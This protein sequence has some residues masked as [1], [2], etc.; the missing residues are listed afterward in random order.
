MRNLK[1]KIFS[2]IF[3]LF[4]VT[5]GFSARL[6]DI[7]DIEGVRGNYLIGY[8]LV[9][10]LKGTGDGVLSKFTVQSVVNMLERFGIKVP[11]EQIILKNV[12]AV[13]VT[14]YLPPFAMPGQRI[15][16]EVSSLG[17]AKS[18]QGGTLLLTPLL[19]P[20]GKVYA[21]AQ[22]PVSLGG[23]AAE[24]AGARIQTAHPTAG[25]IP[26][27]AIVERP[28]EEGLKF[29]GLP[30]GTP[31]EIEKI[32][33]KGEMDLQPRITLSL[34]EPDFS[35]AYKIAETINIYLKGN[36]AQP[37]DNRNIELVIP[38]SYR[39]K[40]I[41]LLA[42]LENLE[43]P[44]DIPAK[45]VIDERT[46]TVVIGE[47]VRISKVAIAHG[48]ISIQVKEYPEVYQPYPFSP[49]E[50]VVV[51]RTEIEAK[52]KKA[53]VVILEEGATLGEL[54]RALNAVGATATE[55]ISILQAIKAAGALQ[56]ELIII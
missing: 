18:L 11:K 25:K 33:K 35:T 41:K 17:D 8:G 30:K 49:G 26:N 32:I 38:S 31:E 1:I 16:V 34:K 2:L 54:V 6:K 7:V 52:E 20:D 5:S 15:D 36:Y 43:I 10:G 40:E 19:G 48:N 45:V 56:A 29:N 47:N 13:L 9:V 4:L 55:L 51:P 46:G 21:L 37:K 44:T 28:V 12:A 22:G 53:K 14:A 27:G 39:E 23:F 24:G 50:T 3:S 42:E